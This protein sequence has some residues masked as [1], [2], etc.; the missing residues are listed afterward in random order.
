MKPAADE[1]YELEPVPQMP[2]TYRATVYGDVNVEPVTD[3]FM[4]A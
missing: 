3:V 1:W 4:V 2:G